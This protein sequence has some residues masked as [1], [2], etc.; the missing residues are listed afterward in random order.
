LAEQLAKKNSNVFLVSSDKLD[1]EAVT[2]DLKIR[3]NVKVGYLQLDLR[4]FDVNTFMKNLNQKFGEIDNLFFVA[5]LG[6]D[7]DIGAVNHKTAKNLIKVNFMSGIRIINAFLPTLMA[8][9][10]SNIVAIGSVVSVRGR[11]K[12]IIYG[13]SKRGLE[14]YFEALRH[15]LENENCK[16]QFYRVGFMSTSMLG[17]RKTFLPVSNPDDV[18]TNILTNLNKNQGMK[19]IPFWWWYISWVLSKLPWNIFKKIHV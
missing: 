8:K 19:F 5:G 7:D 15:R 10:T 12:N 1:L 11:N 3:Y 13:A 9:N 2:N 14:F 4:E 6:D 17:N 18:A 16:V